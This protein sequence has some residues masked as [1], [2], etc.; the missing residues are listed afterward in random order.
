MDDVQLD[1][2]MAMEDM[3]RVLNVLQ[4]ENDNMR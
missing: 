4:Q 1:Q 2:N 3:R